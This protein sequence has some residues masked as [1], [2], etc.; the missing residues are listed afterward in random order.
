MPTATAG[1]RVKLGMFSM[2]FH[3][4]DRDYATILEEDQEALI[5]ADRLGFT[6]AFIGEHFSSWSERITS[7]LIFM[8]TVIGRTKRI[9]LGTGVINLPQLHPATVAA[10]AAMFDHLCRG[11]FIMGIG[12]GGLASDLEM[13]DVGQAELRPQMVQESIDIILKLWS[14]DPPYEINGRFWKFSLKDAIWPEFKVGYLPRPYQQPH[15]PIALSILTPNSASATTAGQRGWIPVSG[16]FFHRRY[17]RGHWER[18]AEGCEQAGR[19]PDPD[20]W[21]VSRSILVTETDAEAE[22][23]LA[24]PETGLS[25]YY[26]FFIHSFT[27]G[28][29]ALFMLKPDL[30]M[31]DEA[32]TVD[33]VKRALIIAGSPRRVL[34][35]LVALRDEVGH[36][37]TL[38]M[39]GHDWD[40]PKLWRRSM[41]LL[42][43]EVMPRLSR[44]A[45]GR[46]R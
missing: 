2:P 14:Q 41:R 27:Q 9:R 34:D 28:R 35:Q 15:P 7:P 43:T 4:P 44:H 24:D 17:L 3:H 20:I 29:K 46:P 19:R 11:R 16:N 21:R 6:E 12:P 36:F 33:G 40:Q 23:Y 5:L 13:F 26:K 22:D 8:A 38:L 18:Y 30:E 1:A 31:P 39:A 32:V 42:A 10:Y 25:F 45:A 37:G